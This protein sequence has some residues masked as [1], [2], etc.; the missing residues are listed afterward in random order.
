MLFSFLGSST[1]I[2]DEVVE[3]IEADEEDGNEGDAHEDNDSDD[4]DDCE[5]GAREDNDSD[6][7][8]WDDG[9]HE[10]N[11]SDDVDDWDDG[12]DE[13]GLAEVELSTD[14]PRTFSFWSL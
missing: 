10:D 5:D 2:C 9:A 6:D 7:D 4:A 3:D 12:A 11:D 8:D 14:A 13:V 1:V